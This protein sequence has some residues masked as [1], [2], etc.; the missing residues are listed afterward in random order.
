MHRQVQRTRRERTGGAH[1]AFQGAGGGAAPDD[2]ASGARVGSTD[3]VGAELER[4]RVGG[5]AICSRDARD[6]RTS[7]AQ[8]CLVRAADLA[9]RFSPSSTSRACSA[10]SASARSSRASTPRSGGA[11]VGCVALKGAAL[12]RLDSVRARRAADGRRRS[13]GVRSRSAA[14]RDGD[15]RHRLRRVFNTHR[16]RVYEP[17]DKHA[18]SGFGEHVDNPLTIE[19]HTAVTEAAARARGRHHCA[20]VAAAESSQ[21]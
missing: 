18:L 3:G 21:A 19:V 14:D 4:N 5:C 16:H 8:A 20:L 2:R 7:R 12:R 11:G 17:R 9:E 15:G 13:A 10:T 6:L 1:P